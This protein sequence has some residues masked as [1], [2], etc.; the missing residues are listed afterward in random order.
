MHW[1]GALVLKSEKSG[2][3]AIFFI[4]VILFMFC[5]VCIGGDEVFIRLSR[6]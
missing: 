2:L 5:F 1:N 6:F 3:R 4:F